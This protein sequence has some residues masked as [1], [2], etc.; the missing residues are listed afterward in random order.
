MIDEAIKFIEKELNGFFRIRLNSIE[1]KAVASALVNQDGSP[2]LR[3]ENKVIIML[4]D[5]QEEGVLKNTGVQHS[6]RNGGFVKSPLP[7]HLNLYVLFGA[8]FSAGNYQEALKYV[9]EVI[10]F[11]QV[12]TVFDRSGFP[13]LQNTS[14][15]KLVFEMYHPD[16]Q[17]RN[18]LWSTIGAKYIPSVIYKVKMLTIREESMAQEIPGISGLDKNS[19]PQ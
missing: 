18:N 10:R 1:D 14:I 8:Y 13:A 5:L 7:V 17:A 9:S 6:L 19:E 15:E 11:F 4:V 2:A 12:R 3:E 16:Y